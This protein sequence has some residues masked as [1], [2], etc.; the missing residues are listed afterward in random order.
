MKSAC[1]QQT[2][3]IGSALYVGWDLRD[4][5]FTNQ[6]FALPTDLLQNRPLH[7]IKEHLRR[8]QATHGE[9]N[10]ICPMCQRSFTRKYVFAISAQSS[11]TP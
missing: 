9:R 1:Q 5:T 6:S 7:A 10:F 4:T 8:H 11:Y 3:I 2:P